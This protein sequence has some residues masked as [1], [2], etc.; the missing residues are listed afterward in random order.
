MSLAN[1]LA[2]MQA[3][4]L[5]QTVTLPHDVIEPAAVGW[6]PLAPGWWLL[7]A[8]T[9]LGSTL[10]MRW[11][12][13]RF[14]ALAPLRQALA[15]FQQL[16]QQWQRDRNSRQTCADL[17]ALLKRTARW[18]YPADNVAAMTGTA[19][20]S[21]LIRTSTGAFDE[22]SAQQLMQFYRGADSSA[23]TPPLAACLCWLNGQKDPSHHV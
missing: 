1:V 20:Q 19:W 23:L 8:V 6:W 3:Q 18:R 14:R 7:I 17:S 13:R 10:L 2:Q 22:S 12:W 11:L 15:E 4:A 21:F 5:P 16:E 9:I